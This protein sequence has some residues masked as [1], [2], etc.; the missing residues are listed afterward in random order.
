MRCRG[1]GRQS[2]H[3]PCREDHDED[4]RSANHRGGELVGESRACPGRAHSGWREY[5]GDR[6]RLF[7]SES[8]L[9]DGAYAQRRANRSGEAHRCAR[10]ADALAQWGSADGLNEWDCQ[11]APANPQHT[12]GEPHDD[13]DQTTAWPGDSGLRRLMVG[14][15]ANSA[16]DIHRCDVQK[17]R[18]EK[19]AK[20]AAVKLVGHNH[21]EHNRHH[22]KGQHARQ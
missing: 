13:A 22:R 6:E 16:D 20:D 12:S 18:C 14:L 21:A 9:A 11:N 1:S 2:P 17:K 5:G 19:L 4:K 15:S 7:R 8:M 3:A 10:G